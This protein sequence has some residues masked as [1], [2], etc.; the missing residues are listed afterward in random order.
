M[1][2]SIK[3]FLFIVVLLLIGAGA[4]YVM[5]LQSDN[6]ILKANEQE[7]KTAIEEQQ[8]VLEQQK[9]SYEQILTANNE[10]NSKVAELN[11]ARDEL[12]NKLAKHDMNYL[13]VEK[14]GLIERIINK[15][16]K[17]VLNEIE[18]LTAE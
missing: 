11:R 1:F 15:G 3:L 17:D 12:Q 13:A 14:P 5:K 2:Q 8:Q 4:W 10:L 18:T 16:S 9:Q 7:L 6:A